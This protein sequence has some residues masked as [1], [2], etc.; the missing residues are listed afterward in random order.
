MFPKMPAK[1][2]LKFFTVFSHVSRKCVSIY[3]SLYVYYSAYLVSDIA[4]EQHDYTAVVRSMS[5]KIF[6]KFFT[7]SWHVSS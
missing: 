2:L 1:V 4:H 3:R 7:V 5:P 6:I